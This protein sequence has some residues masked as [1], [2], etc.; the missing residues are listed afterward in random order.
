MKV[1]EMIVKVEKLIEESYTPEQWKE[2]LQTVLADLNPIAKI[3]ESVETDVTLTDGAG[4]IKLSEKIPSM[5]EIVSVAYKPTAG[6]KRLLKKLSSFDSVSVGWYRDSDNIYLQNIEY[7]AGKI[8]V[9]YY[10][11]LTIEDGE[12]NLPEKYHELVI[13]GMA[14]IAMQKEEELDRKSDF[15]GE[16]MLMK[17]QMQA[18]RIMEMEPWYAQVVA[19]ARLGG[20]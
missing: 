19:P 13:K 2:F 18:E 5:Y 9:D 1:P 11:L 3:L 4:S 10:E 14:G 16:Y 6:R 12:I 8:V 17:K 15:F 7:G 20:Q